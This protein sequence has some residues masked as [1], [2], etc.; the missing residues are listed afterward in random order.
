[1]QMLRTIRKAKG[2]TMK[3]LGEKVGV[4]ESAIS[5]YETG[6]READFGT[7]MRLSK[8]FNTS[9][10]DLLDNKHNLKQDECSKLFRHNLS[11]ALEQLD[12][13]FSG[14][15][16]AEYDY[17]ELQ[18]LV[19]AT[20]PLTLKEVDEAADIIGV[21]LHDLFREDYEGYLQN[22]ESPGAEKS[23]P[24]DNVE[25]EI[26]GLVGKMSPEQ[27]NFLIALLNTTIARN[28][29]MPVAGQVS[30]GAAAPEFENRGPTR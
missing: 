6:K 10:D 3:E 20:Y 29:E 27:K 15:P 30:V 22:K 9:I 25:Q 7:I 18:E 4:S 21:P 1:M 23:A 16:E 13:G 24:R 26:M 5:Q 8:F 28:Q 14:V 19:D 2:L 12:S 17:Q 11:I